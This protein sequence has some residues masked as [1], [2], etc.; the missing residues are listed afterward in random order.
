MPLNAAQQAQRQLI[1]ALKD[2]ARYPH[3]VKGVRVIET[4][5]SFVLLTGLFAYKIKKAV[6]LGFIDYASLE[7]RRFFCSEELRLNRR[8]A[9]QL[10]LA[11]VSISGTPEHPCIGQNAVPLEYAV[12]MAEFSQ[13]D[14][15]DR[16]LNRSELTARHIDTLATM[17]A[18][19]HQH[20]PSAD[21]VALFGSPPV[22][23]APVEANFVFF[24]Q[25]ASVKRRQLAR[26]QA[27]AETEYARLYATFVQRKA[28][29]WIRECHG[30][31]HLGNML[32]L[33]QQ[34][35]IFDCI[36]FNAE[37]RWIDV[38]NDLA[39]LIMD[40]VVHGR[41]DYAW[42]LLNGWLELTGDYAGLETLRFYEAYRALVRAKVSGLQAEDETL[43]CSDRKA[44]LA[45]QAAYLDYAS[46]VQRIRPPALI[47]THGF[48]G[49]GKSTVARTVAA[50][51]GAIY[52]RSDVERKRLHGL[53]PLAQSESEINAGLYTTAATKAVYRRLKALAGIVLQ[54]GYSVIVDAAFLQCWQRQLFYELAE[55]THV[56]LLILD[57]QASEA[58]LLQRLA[59][60][61]RLGGDASEATAVVLSKQLADSEPLRQEELNMAVIVDTS[62]EHRAIPLAEI[63]LRLD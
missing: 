36:E 24:H 6:N 41:P 18:G 54:A 34:P 1:E 40:F 57:C 15:L 50:E 49:S 23:W 39:F 3:P 19:F 26:L 30:D 48:S 9:P 51:L 13:Q 22:I 31:L 28:A 10:Y 33:D 47:I 17:L 12:K 42:R 7:Q 2:P 60:R 59:M 38:F 14:L 5:I 25:H 43:S 62:E 35:M 29:G 53:P 52:V 32:L 58:V 55:A 44:V 46:T 61:S 27:W 45:R 4:H 11:I 63:R 20:A 56:P 8:L 16:V 21:A 37:L